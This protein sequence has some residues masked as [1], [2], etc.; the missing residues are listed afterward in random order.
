MVIDN[1]DLAAVWQ[2]PIA[3]QQTSAL[4]AHRIDARAIRP[5]EHRYCLGTMAFDVHVLR[6][7]AEAISVIVTDDGL[8]TLLG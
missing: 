7:P 5:L 4:V 1:N 8:P 2:T 6:L 3:A